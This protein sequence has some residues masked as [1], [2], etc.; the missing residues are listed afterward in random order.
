MRPNKKSPGKTFSGAKKERRNGKQY[1][2]FTY[3]YKQL[4]GK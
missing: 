4:V 1:Q 3:L 2:P